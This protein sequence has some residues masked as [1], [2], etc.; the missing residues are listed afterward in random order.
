[1]IDWEQK[2][3]V[4]DDDLLAKIKEIK[5]AYYD[6]LSAG[7]LTQ[8]IVMDVLPQNI[9]LLEGRY[10]IAGRMS[11]TDITVTGFDNNTYSLPI[12]TVNTMITE[13]GAEAV[14]QYDKWQAKRVY[15][16]DLARTPE[17]IEAV[18]WESVD[19]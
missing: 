15:I 9:A 6:S 4:F 10:N 17:E 1:M 16:N 12:A 13:L 18:T 8:T 11:E 19:V 14:T 2:N 5:Q 7:F 3:S